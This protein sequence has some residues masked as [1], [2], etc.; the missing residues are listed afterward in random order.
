MSAQHE[1]SRKEVK[2]K[3][4]KT[5]MSTDTPSSAMPFPV[6]LSSSM[7]LLLSNA[8]ASALAPLSWMRL[9]LMLSCSRVVFL[10]NPFWAMIQT[11]SAVMALALRSIN[12]TL[13]FVCRQ[14]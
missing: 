7:D 13:V 14:R 4:K 10:Q 3:R 5:C 6:M 1:P 2:L 12:L 11:P 9:S 8:M